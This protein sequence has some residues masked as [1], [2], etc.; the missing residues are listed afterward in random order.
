M[1]NLKTIGAI[2]CAALLSFAFCGEALA[3]SKKDKT[4]T[5]ETTTKRKNSAKTTSNSVSLSTGNDT[6]AEH[7]PA[8]PDG[9]S[10]NNKYDVKKFEVESGDTLQ[11]TLSNNKTYKCIIY[12]VEVPKDWD[13]EA[14]KKHLKEILTNA[15]SIK[16]QVFNGKTK[17]KT[18]IGG[19][20]SSSNPVSGS[21]GGTAANESDTNKTLLVK[22]ISSS[23]FDFGKLMIQDGY[24]TSY[25]AEIDTKGMGGDAYARAQK[26][27]EKAK[28]GLWNPEGPQ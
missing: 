7:K 27:A 21:G 13:S 22:L 10:E 2:F 4:T 17:S 16:V 23:N 24:A 18:R 25:D 19:S 11:L 3:S 14:S 9:L 1:K 15:K 6:K 12:G 28:K 5:T 20:T 8:L 26:Q